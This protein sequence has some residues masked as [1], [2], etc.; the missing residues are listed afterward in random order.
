MY[1]CI[2]V[3]LCT[4]HMSHACTYIYIISTC[5]HACLEMQ[6]TWYACTFPYMVCMH[7]TV[8]IYSST[9]KYII[10][11]HACSMYKWCVG[12]HGHNLL[13]LLDMIAMS[14]L[15]DFTYLGLCLVKLIFSWN[16]KACQSRWVCMHVSIHGMYALHGSIYRQHYVYHVCTCMQHV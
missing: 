5:A 4:V 3:Y 1:T 2:Y 9:H 10:Y 14:S 13:N 6:Y 12:M 8:H 11:V 16:Q 15:M 7:C